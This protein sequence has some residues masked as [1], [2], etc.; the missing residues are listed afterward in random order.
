MSR[1]HRHGGHEV[2]KK[3]ER[4]ATNKYQRTAA[5]EFI[6]NVKKNEDYS[7][8]ES[9]EAFKYG[10]DSCYFSYWKPIRRWLTS[11]LNRP[12]DQVYSELKIKLTEMIGEDQ[13]SRCIN[14]AVEIVP[15]PRYADEDKTRF[16]NYFYVE[17]GILKKAPYK[18]QRLNYCKKLPFKVD[19]LLSWLN[20]RVAGEYDGKMFWHKEITGSKKRGRTGDHHQLKCEFESFGSL[21]YVYWK[22]FVVRDNFGEIVKKESKWVRHFPYTRKDTEFSKEDYDFWNA[23]PE[24]YKNQVLMFSTKRIAGYFGWYDY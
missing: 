5:R 12:W 10:W 23:L 2:F 21:H 18:R 19:R 6:S 20:G 13:A 24:Y 8:N 22:T 4:K 9:I 11:N 3:L 7:S 1:T 15:N 14:S 17:N 16:R